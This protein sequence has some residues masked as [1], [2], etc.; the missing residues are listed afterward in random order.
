MAGMRRKT[1]QEQKTTKKANMGGAWH[2]HQWQ[3]GHYIVKVVLENMVTGVAQH[4]FIF[5]HH[6]P[7]NSA[8]TQWRLYVNTH[9]QGLCKDKVTHHH[10][11]N[12]LPLVYMLGTPPRLGNHVNWSSVQELRSSSFVRILS[13]N[14]A[15]VRLILDIHNPYSNAQD[16]VVPIMPS[17][18]P[19]PIFPLKMPSSAPSIFDQGVTLWVL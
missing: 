14:T 1:S 8:T 6:F 19:S 12:I 16:H 10:F 9:T 2:K 3:K 18:S 5:T 4:I 17:P 13:L 11:M 15:W 7:S